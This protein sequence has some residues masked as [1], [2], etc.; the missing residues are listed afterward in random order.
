MR[1]RKKII[2]ASSVPQHAESNYVVNVKKKKNLKLNNFTKKK[3]HRIIIT[4]P[5]THE[6]YN[7]TKTIITRKVNYYKPK[8][9]HHYSSKSWK[10]PVPFDIHKFL[11]SGT[12]HCNRRLKYIINA[13]TKKKSPQQ[14]KNSTTFPIMQG[15]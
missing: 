4:K 12:P 3:N 7:I 13:H 15:R 10:K 5:I 2:I 1:R 11:S 14:Q 9:Y 6:K 8:T